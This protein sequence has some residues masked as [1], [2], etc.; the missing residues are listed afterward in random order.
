MPSIQSGFLGMVIPFSSPVIPERPLSTSGLERRSKTWDMPWDL[1]CFQS[2]AVRRETSAER[3]SRRGR[4][5]PLGVVRGKRAAS[6]RLLMLLM[7][8][9]GG[10]GRGGS[11]VEL[12][13][14]M[15]VDV[16]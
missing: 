14:D 6:R 9:K 15:V 1:S 7:L 16:C 4:R 10:D 5:G 13:A 3:K 8:R 2:G 12:D 11:M